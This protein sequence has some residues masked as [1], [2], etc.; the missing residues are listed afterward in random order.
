MIGE[1]K[2]KKILAIFLV[3]CF[4]LCLAACGNKDNSGDLSN[5]NSHTTSTEIQTNTSDEAGGSGETNEPNSSDAS[6]NTDNANDSNSSNGSGDLNNNNSS[7]GTNNSNTANSLSDSNN[8]NSS[9][10][11]NGANGTNNS[12]PPPHTHSYSDATCTAP[13]K[14]SCGATNGSA[15][16]HEWKG[17]TCEAP[18]TC[19]VCK[20]TEG[21]KLEHVVEGE[22]CKWCKQVV[23]VTPNKFN[24]NITYS[25]IGAK[26]DGDPFGYP[27]EYDCYVITYLILNGY[28]HSQGVCSE[29]DEKNPSGNHVKPYHHN[30]KYYD[31]IA[32]WHGINGE[33]S[34]KIV[35]SEIIITTQYSHTEKMVI[36]FELLSNGTLKVKSIS[37]PALPEENGVN[38]GSLFYPNPDP[39]TN[40]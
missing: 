36:K 33:T 11:S 37:G 12:N 8:T 10:N 7:S 26:Y 16:G 34:Y 17:A 30:G 14:C 24:A 25:C 40:E 35:N 22:T 13:A 5:D 27:Q 39:E 20:I 19:S 3:T 31:S 38:V 4:I 2:M 9:N 32:Q 1:N 18:K 6:N 29:S 23:P 15:L 28:S 21:N